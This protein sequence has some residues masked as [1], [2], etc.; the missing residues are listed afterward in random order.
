MNTDN[1]V[2]R[3]GYYIERKGFWGRAAIVLMLLSAGFR[4]IGCWGMWKDPAFALTQMALPICC[5]LLFALCILLLGK[6]GFVLSSIPVLLGVVF[7][8]IKSFGF[9]SKIHMVLCIL[10]Y[11]IVAVIYTGTLCGSIGTKWLL[12]PLFG[13]PFIYHLAVEDIPALQ[14]PDI[15]V[16]FT[17]GMQEISVLCIMAALFCTGMGLKKREPK[18]PEPELPKIKDPVV[19]VPAEETETESQPAA[20]EAA[21]AEAAAE[22]AKAENDAAPAE[23]AGNESDSE[24]RETL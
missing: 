11:L 8:I 19:I 15:T 24:I 20:E 6:K 1:K 9:E 4:L 12:P 7:F 18:Q 10:L 17:A 3:S 14:N 23:T 22:E 21:P 16:S 5:N 2:K 13:L